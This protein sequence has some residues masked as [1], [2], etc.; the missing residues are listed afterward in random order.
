MML[1]ESLVGNLGIGP[2]KFNEEF[3]RELNGNS[4]TERLAYLQRFISYIDFDV[5]KV[6]KLL[7][8]STQK[9]MKQAS[10]YDKEVI[11]KDIVKEFADILSFGIQYCYTS[12]N[13]IRPEGIINYANYMLYFNIN[14]QPSIRIIDLPKLKDCYK[15]LDSIFKTYKTLKMSTNS[16]RIY[17]IKD[18]IKDLT[19]I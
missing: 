7:H 5:D 3:F 17:Y 8:N 18:S 15:T 10:Y 2:H 9:Y 1:Y 4:K 11:T 12:K 19:I 13:G 6:T 16:Y 14:D